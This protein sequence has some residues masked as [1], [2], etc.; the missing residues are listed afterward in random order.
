MVRISSILLPIATSIFCAYFLNEFEFGKYSKLARKTKR[1]DGTGLNAYSERVNESLCSAGFGIL[2]HDVWDLSATSDATDILFG[3][4]KVR[5]L[6]WN[7]WFDKTAYGS[8]VVGDGCNI[9]DLS[10]HF[11]SKIVQKAGSVIGIISEQ[12]MDIEANDEWFNFAEQSNFDAFGWYTANGYKAY[13][14]QSESVKD[15]FVVDKSGLHIRIILDFDAN[16]GDAANLIFKQTKSK[17]HYKMYNFI[18]NKAKYRLAVS[19]QM[20]EAFRLL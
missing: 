16:N 19:S 11:N 2:H 6:G 9:W 8:I 10:H 18:D 7:T 13:Q 17:K 15:A 1:A 4:R 20:E 14:G 3:N 12:S 5:M